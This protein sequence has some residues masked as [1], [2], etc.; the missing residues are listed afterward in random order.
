[1]VR[2]LTKEE[3]DNLKAMDQCLDEAVRLVEQEIKAQAKSD[4]PDFPFW[5]EVDK[6]I[7]TYQ[8]L[9]NKL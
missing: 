3:S 7:E 4:D 8:K 1:M 5:S 2:Q 6:T 9:L